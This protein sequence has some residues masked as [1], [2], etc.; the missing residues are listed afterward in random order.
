LVEERKYRNELNALREYIFKVNN[1]YIPLASVKTLTDYISSN[2]IIIIGGTK[3]WRRRFREKYPELRS[4]H[5]F[6][7]NFDTSILVNYD[8]V[9]FYTGFMN[10][11]T[12]YKAMSFIRN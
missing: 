11:A 6:N 10:H 2:K 8:Y 1:D 3:E 4:L 7:E 12:Y 5:G 9:F